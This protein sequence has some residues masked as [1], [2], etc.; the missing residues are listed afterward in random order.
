MQRNGM[1]ILKIFVSSVQKELEN[2]RIAVTELVSS[3]P[4]S[5]GISPPSCSSSFPQIS[6]ISEVT[7]L[8]A[9]RSCNLYIASSVFSTAGKVRTDCPQHT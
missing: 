9:L 8:E 1:S 4:F 5:T 7:Y 6:Q 3:D 2:E